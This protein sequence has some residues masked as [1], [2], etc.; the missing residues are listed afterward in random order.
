MSEE[1]K[2]AETDTGK[3]TEQV[4]IDK[5]EL[6]GLRAS[7]KFSD[8]LTQKA[9]DILGEGY[10]REEYVQT[11]EDTANRA[12]GLEDEIEK[13]KEVKPDAKET[14]AAPKEPVPQPAG[15]SDD[16]RKLIEQGQR[17]ST[18]AYL[19]ANYNGFLIRQNALPEENRSKRTKMDLLKFI[20]GPKSSLVADIAK[21]PQFEGNVFMVA[22][23]L[24]NEAQTREKQAQEVQTK[25]SA[26]EK[27]K[28]TANIDT[29]TVGAPADQ[30]EKSENEKAADAIVQDDPEVVLT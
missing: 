12:L 18:T 8:E 14:P 11:V 22:E 19:D 26:I 3:S 2:P 27:A 24:L 1:N 28:V 15:L 21:D 30:K 13:A 6:E 20:N 25:E 23:Y 9:Q 4:Q 7:Q 10:T 16:D 29:S 17:M 5:A